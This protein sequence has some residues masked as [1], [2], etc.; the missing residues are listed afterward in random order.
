MAVWIFSPGLSQETFLAP[1]LIWP[2]CSGL[3]VCHCVSPPSTVTEGWGPPLV[4]WDS[5][6]AEAWAGLKVEGG[7]QDTSLWLPAQ[8]GQ[9]SWPLGCLG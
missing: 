9:L 8:T 1:S 6:A 4:T 5:G 2:G 3:G 7:T